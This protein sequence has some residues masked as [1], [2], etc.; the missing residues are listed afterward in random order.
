MIDS[1][2]NTFGVNDTLRS[3]QAKNSSG[4]VFCIA[5]NGDEAILGWANVGKERFRI[6]Q[7]SL[8]N[9]AW[10]VVDRPQTLN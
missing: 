5:I 8:S 10:V 3:I 6:N 1:K 4:D 2:G 7:I 9:S